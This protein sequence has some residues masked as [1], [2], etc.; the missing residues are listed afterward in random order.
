[1]H[2]DENNYV[3]K[4]EIKKTTKEKIVPNVVSNKV[5]IPTANTRYCRIPG[6]TVC[7]GMYRMKEEVEN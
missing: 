1:M 4:L 6:C 5:F 3:E 2:Y 7:N